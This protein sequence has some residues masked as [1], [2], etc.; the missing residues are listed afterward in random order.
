MRTYAEEKSATTAVQ[1]DI[2]DLQFHRLSSTTNPTAMIETA[3]E[4]K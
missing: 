4:L 1:Q 2:A 3:I